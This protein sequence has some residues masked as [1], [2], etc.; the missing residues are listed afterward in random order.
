[1]HKIP[2]LL[3]LIFCLSTQAEVIHLKNIKAYSH[4]G[5][6]LEEFNALL[7]DTDTGQ[8]LEINP[9]N[10]KDAVTI[11]G[12]GKA[13]LP[14]LHDAHG[15]I[16]EY[17]LSQLLVNVQGIKS[18][19][20]TI[21]TTGDYANKNPEYPW[22]LGRGWN[23]VLW[24][25]K[26]FPSRYDLDE[27]SKD[28][29]IWLER[30]DGHAGWANSKALEIAGI[31]RESAKG[32]DLI[33]K[34]SEGLPT[35]ILIDNAMYKV[36]KHIPNVS[37]EMKRKAMD[38]ALKDLA[39]VGLTFVHD[40]GIGQDS[41]EIFTD[42]ATDN[43]LPIRVYAML[44]SGAETYEKLLAKG[45]LNIENHFIIRSVKLMIDGALGSYGAMMHEPYSDKPEMQGAYVQTP[46]QIQN[47]LDA[48]IKA[49]FQAN[50]HAI[51]D[52]GNTEVIDL[53]IR[54]GMQTSQLR[55][56][57]E[58]AQILRLDDIIK[59]K[60]HGLIAS[61]Q[62]T[63]ATSDMNMAEDRVGSERIKGAYAWQKL[64][65]AGVVVA[66]GSDFP[67]ELI[68]P[69]HGLHAAVTRQNHQNQPPGGWYKDQAMSVEQALQ[70]FT[71]NAA[72]AAHA[73]DFSGSLEVGKQADFIVVNQDI[74]VVDPA[75]IWKTEVLETW[76]GGVKIFK[77]DVTE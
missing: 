16:L 14:G 69:F 72:F 6:Q 75:E 67:V 73:E 40:A 10:L 64:F 35:G 62:P 54:N 46:E 52:R 21:K 5:Q 55:H 39:S 7:F 59:F 27:I 26:A 19:S 48:V 31:T 50:V 45:Q 33:L 68:N 24:A 12:Q 9:D 57:V 36:K 63:H 15:H 11:N 2:T 41:Y 20:G 8:L 28:K 25:G 29:P 32:D 17:G 66:S 47:K 34:D 77:R 70:S 76:V 37:T 74:F 53:L 18:L 30:V 51:G 22:I 38:L 3:A 56:R 23:Q 43:N 1:M 44:A 13:V 42:L 4:N 71:I 49:D 65:D 61:M 60:Q 58:H